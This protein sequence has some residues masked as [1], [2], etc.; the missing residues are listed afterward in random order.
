LEGISLKTWIGLSS[1]PL[2]LFACVTVNKSI[3]DR[4]FMAAPV[5]T[6]DVYVYLPGDEVPPHTRVAI[7]NA[8]GDVDMTNEGEIIEKLREEAGKL[9]ANAV[10]MGEIA[11][12]S[13][14]AIVAKAFLD[15]EANRTAQAIAVFVP[16]LKKG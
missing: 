11:D 6:E 10:I 9:G 1:L 2:I 13:T 12:P 8:E 4:S 16:S 14:A 15:T 3:L 7:L 5:P